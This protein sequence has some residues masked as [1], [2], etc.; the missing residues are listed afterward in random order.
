[1]TIVGERKVPDL[2]FLPPSL[3]QLKELRGISRSIDITGIESI[4]NV[5]L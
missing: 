4:K 5:N 2:A 1:L 3:K